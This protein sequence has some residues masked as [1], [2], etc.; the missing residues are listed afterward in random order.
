LDNWLPTEPKPY[1][2][3]QS[4]LYQR[5]HYWRNVE[6]SRQKNRAYRSQRRDKEREQSRLRRSLQLIRVINHY[7]NGKNECACCKIKNSLTIDHINGGGLKHKKDNAISQGGFYAWLIKNQ[8]PDGFQ[9]LCFDC[10]QSKS[11]GRIRCQIDHKN[12]EEVT[13]Q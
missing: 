7:S 6:I 12:H 9:V 11:V 8:F 4:P 2:K 10:N 3:S 5:I 1:R 13:K